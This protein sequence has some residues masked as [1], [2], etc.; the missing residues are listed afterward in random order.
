M[1]IQADSKYLKTN[2][3]T[4]RRDEDKEKHP[5]KHTLIQTT[6]TLGNQVSITES[7]RVGQGMECNKATPYFVLPFSFGCACVC[8]CVCVNDTGFTVTF[9]YTYIT[10]L[11][12]FTPYYL[13]LS[14]LS[15][16]HYAILVLTFHNFKIFVNY[17]GCPCS[18]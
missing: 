10:Y 11:N 9:A 7:F 16:L 6:L 4:R 12:M 17:H 2:N 13:L 15:L 8:V 1:W 5:C 3:S 14:P 18:C